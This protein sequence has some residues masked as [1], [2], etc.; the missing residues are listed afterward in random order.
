MMALPWFAL[1]PQIISRWSK[2]LFFSER[3]L[4][5]TDYRSKIVQVYLAIDDQDEENSAM[6]MIEGSHRLGALVRQF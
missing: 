5:I 6:K 2:E 1:R 4:V 3:L